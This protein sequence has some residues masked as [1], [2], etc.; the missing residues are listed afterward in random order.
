MHY[1]FGQDFTLKGLLKWV[2]FSSYLLVLS[3]GMV[4]DVIFSVQ[5]NQ[6]F[7]YHYICI[8]RASGN[9]LLNVNFNIIWGPSNIVLFEV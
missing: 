2:S 5:G 9:S 7:C 6:I 4:K 3:L 1:H 8:F